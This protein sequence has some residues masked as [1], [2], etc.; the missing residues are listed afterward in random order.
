MSIQKNDVTLSAQH[1]LNSDDLRFYFEFS[2]MADP[3]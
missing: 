2:Y 1:F 3:P